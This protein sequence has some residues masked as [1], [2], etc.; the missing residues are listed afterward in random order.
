MSLLEYLRIL[1]QRGWIILLCGA[2]FA[3]AMYLYSSQQA[4]I[5]QSTQVVLLQPARANQS[6]GAAHR[7]LLN[8]YVVYLNSSFIAQEIAD[9]LDMGISGAE[10]KGRTEI[11]AIPDRLTIEIKVNDTNGDNANRVAFAWG[12]KLIQLRQAQNANLP[13]DDHINAILQDFPTYTQFSPRTFVNMALGGIVGI[14]VGGV[15]VFILEFRQH[16]VIRYQDDIETLLGQQTL[17]SIPAE[18]H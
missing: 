12:E 8:S 9:S 3:G 4:V 10:L 7:S 6:I 11:G 17:V 18:I 13:N 5:Y 2:L 15:I 16:R 1:I 14:L